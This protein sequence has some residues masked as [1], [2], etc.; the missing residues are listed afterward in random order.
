MLKEK[1]AKLESSLERL[2]DRRDSREALLS[3][4]VPEDMRQMYIADLMAM[5]KRI[6]AKENSII[7]TKNRI[8]ELQR[9]VLLREQQVAAAMTRA[10][11]E[12]P[13]WHQIGK[14]SITR[15]GCSC[16]SAE[17]ITI[18]CALHYLVIEIVI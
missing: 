14:V 3:G 12:Q 6:A 18:S 11:Q 2:Q 9:L 1:V 7:A 17:L 10:G 13:S 4:S 16:E 5:S 15:A 8:V